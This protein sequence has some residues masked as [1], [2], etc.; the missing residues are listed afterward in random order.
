MLQQYISYDKYF[1]PGIRVKLSIPLSGGEIFREWAEVESLELDVILL[2]LSRTILPEHVLISIGSILELRIIA[3]TGSFC[4][5]GIVISDYDGQFLQI[6]LISEIITNELREYF[7]I[8]VFLPIRAS[9]P[10][11]QDPD[12]IMEE[13]RERRRLLTDR[14][15]VEEAEPRQEIDW[16]GTMPASVN[17]SGGGLRCKIP[18]RT[19]KG[20]LLWV[21]LQLPLSSPRDLLLIGKVVYTSPITID[22]ETLFDTAMHFFFID[23]RDRDAIINYISEMELRRIREFKK[24][25]LPYSLTHDNEKKGSRWETILTRAFYAILCTFAV[26]YLVITLL[27]YRKNRKESEIEKAFEQSI[28][29]YAEKIRNK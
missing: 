17:I 14:Y 16:S 6:E 13:W 26:V 24:H 1:K 5:R 22:G 3:N 20:D 12:R 15:A 25:Y 10:A 8:D 9:R 28:K 7:R 27:N 4:C 29:E 21:E 19:E 2:R 18:P 23:E 11:E